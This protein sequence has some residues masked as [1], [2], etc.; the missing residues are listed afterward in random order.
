MGRRRHLGP[1]LGQGGCWAPAL[2]LRP[3]SFFLPPPILSLFFFLKKSLEQ[4]SSYTICGKQKFI[5]KQ[6]CD[7][8][9]EQDWRKHPGEKSLRSLAGGGGGES[10]N[11]RMHSWAESSPRS[12]SQWAASLLKLSPLAGGEMLRAHCLLAV[13]Q[14]VSHG[15]DL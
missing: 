9:E 14:A 2:A 6:L 11:T 5:K 7:G 12:L 3:P 8:R 13:H 1:G 15:H 10:W 4:P